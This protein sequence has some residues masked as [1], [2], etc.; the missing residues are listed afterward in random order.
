MLKQNKFFVLIFSLFILILLLIPGQ[1][2]L[3]S[4]PAFEMSQ[5]ELSISDGYLHQK[6]GNF[7]WEEYYEDGMVEILI[8]LKEKADT[9]KVAGEAKREPGSTKDNVAVAVVKSLREVAD[10]TQAPL[11]GYLKAKK[12]EG[13]VEEIKSFYIINVV[14]AHVSVDMIDEIAARPE[15]EAVRPNGKI[16]LIEPVEST[17]ATPQGSGIEWNIERV[18]APEVWDLGYDGSGVV[19][20]IIDTGVD[21]NHEALLRKYRGYDP[22]GN[23][24]HAYNW[25]D[26]YYDDRHEPDDE[27]GHGTHC[28]GTV[29]GSGSDENNQIGVAPGARWIAA[30]GL[31]DRKGYG[32]EAALI[33]SAQFLLAPTPNSDGTGDPDPTKRPDII[34]NSWGGGLGLDEWYLEMVNNWRAVGIMPVFGAGNSG[35]GYGSV[36]IPGNYPVSF[37]VAAT[38][39]HDELAWFSSRGAAPYEHPESMQPNISAPG[40]DIR[41]AVPGGGYDSRAGTSMAA[42]H[43][44]GV[45]ALLLQYNSTFTVD[46]LENIIMNSAIS[47]TDDVYPVS[48]N[49]GYGYGLVDALA[50]LDGNT[51]NPPTPLE[52][53]LP[54]P[55]EDSAYAWVLDTYHPWIPRGPVTIQVP[56]AN[57]GVLQASD[58]LYVVA[59]DFVKNFWYVIAYNHIWFID[60]ETGNYSSIG[61]L[62]YIHDDYWLEYSGLA[63]DLEEEKLYASVIAYDWDD[64]S[65]MP[66]LDHSYLCVIDVDTAQTQFIGKISGDYD[67]LFFALAFDSDGNMYGC[68]MTYCFDEDSYLYSINKATGEGTLV[69]SLGA[70]FWLHSQDLAFGHDEEILYGT[71]YNYDTAMPGIYEI[72]TSTGTAALIEDTD[73]FISGFAIP[74]EKLPPHTAEVILM[75]EPESPTLP[76]QRITFTAVSEGIDQPVEYAFYYRVEGATSWTLA[77]G[78]STVNTFSATVKAE[79]NYQVRV[80]ARSSGSVETEAEDIINHVVSYP[81]PVDSVS[82]IAVPESPTVPGEI[83]TFSAQA[84]GGF[85]PEYAFY[86][87]SDTGSPWLLAQGYSDENQL[88]VPIHRAGSYQVAAVARSAG[89]IATY[90]ASQVLGHIVAIPAVELVSLAADPPGPAAPGT[91][92]TF[93]AA[94]EGG[95]NPEYAFYYRTGPGVPWNLASPYSESNTFTAKVNT[96]GDYEVA[97]VVR[98]KGSTA[99]WE[100]SDTINYSIADIIR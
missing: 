21:L 85:N 4:S 99:A 42:P 58:D 2:L 6:T 89:S 40:V 68:E 18:Q 80:T 47:L 72:D 1:G 92:I 79:G 87:R 25:F 51:S 91:T 27:D 41:S 76:G 49:Y 74:Q 81:P 56:E 16:E 32:T 78:Y 13:K 77:R 88:S 84:E 97:V 22:D 31:D 15:V 57:I 38:N 62:P 37:S 75:T 70:D 26:P 44:A 9:D 14:Y 90:E 63:Y 43:I 95:L 54:L 36:I 93:S 61:E 52:P 66:F 98:S 64:Q 55:L 39:S 3:E 73:Y 71:F 69:G 59:G 46:Q 96:K 83:V 82:L 5:R 100:A 35:P 60:T 24:D 86:Y 23:H 65:G 8:R 33:A 19:V 30:R 29:L 45:A 48:P 67:E 11:L 53:S 50:A 20:G 7:N 34:N 10:H 17:G 28:T 12:T 94:A